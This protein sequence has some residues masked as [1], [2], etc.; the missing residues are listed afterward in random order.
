MAIE[1]TSMPRHGRLPSLHAVVESVSGFFHDDPLSDRRLLF[2]F[3]CGLFVL[4]LAVGG[5]S[6]L[7]SYKYYS[8]IVDARLASG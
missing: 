2:R 1:I 8:R 6:L 4:A 3:F 7:N 5:D